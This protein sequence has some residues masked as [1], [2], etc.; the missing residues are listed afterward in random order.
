MDQL[1]NLTDILGRHAPVDGTHACPLPGVKLIRAS[2]PTLPMPAVYEPTLCLVAQGRKRAVLGSTAFIYDPASFLIAS[3]DLPVM[4]AVTQASPDRPY[5]CLQLD[6]DMAALGELAIRHPVTH[7]NPNRL[8]SGLT[9]NR[10]TPALLDAALRLAGLLDMPEDI[11]GLAPLFTR[12]ILYRLL[13]GASGGAIRQMAQS[14][15]RLNQISRA[16]VWIRTHFR[17]ACP[18]E[19]AAAIAGMS[20]SSF[21]SHFKAVTAMSP[22]EFRTLLRVQEAQRL[23][24]SEACDAASAGFAVGYAS[25]SQ[26]SRDYVRLMGASPAR[27]ANRL[28]NE[29]ASSAADT[30]VQAAT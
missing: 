23:M 9:L 5:L 8:S 21:H 11:R 14:D 25:P 12:E 22:L 20:R 19:Q 16:I 3:V 1:V 30:P 26:F 7:A 29:A 6:L 27:H 13:T 24:V 17:E 28:R 2:A 10:T 15:S 18:I 4:G